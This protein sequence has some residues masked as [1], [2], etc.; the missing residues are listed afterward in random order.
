MWGT[1]KIDMKKKARLESQLKL[2][3]KMVVPTA[4]YGNETCIV[5]KNHETSIQTAEIIF[6]CAVAGYMCSDHEC[7][8]EIR[9]KLNG[10]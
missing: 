1:I 5:K 8:A 2:Y 10:F 7:N 4:T 9:E 6:I 3:K